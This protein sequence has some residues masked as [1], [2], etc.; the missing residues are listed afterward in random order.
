MGVDCVWMVPRLGDE[1]EALVTD[2]LGDRRSILCCEGT[3]MAV[4][5]LTRWAR[6]HDDRGPALRLEEIAP[7]Q[8][9]LYPDCDEPDDLIWT[10]A[11]WSQRNMQQL[12]QARA[13]ALAVLRGSG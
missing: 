5:T 11:E 7:G 4:S 8:M 10:G 3:Y 12:E 13:D 6:R 9:L 2:A 1:T